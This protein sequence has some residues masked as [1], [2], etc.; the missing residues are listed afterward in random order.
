VRSADREELYS[1][2][3]EEIFPELPLGILVDQTTAGPPE[4]LAAALQDNHRAL[5]IGEPT[6]GIAYE[7][8]GVPLADR[9][10]VLV[11][12]TALL[13]RGDGRPLY[14]P[15]KHSGSLEILVPRVVEPH[16]A[17]EKNDERRQQLW[18]VSPDVPLRAFLVAAGTDVRV[19]AASAFRQALKEKQGDAAPAETSR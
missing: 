6:S 9:K 17:G 14:R 15:T 4:W 11:L 10:S 12:P 1:A 5:I 2:E 13:E 18:G 8:T 19:E 3:P 16:A 7:E